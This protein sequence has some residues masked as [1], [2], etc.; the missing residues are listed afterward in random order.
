MKNAVSL[1]FGLTML[2]TAGLGCGLMDRAQ[3][4]DGANSSNSNKTLTDRAVDSTVGDEKIGIPEC[5]AVVDELTG[6]SADQNPDEGYIVKAF[7]KYWQNMIRESIRKSIEE[8]KNDPEK[9]ATEC[10]KIK[11]QL[12]KYKAEEEQKKTN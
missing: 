8:N 9:L 10:R 5:D 6:E 12:D 1:F 11:I 2:I 7:R 4:P 3:E